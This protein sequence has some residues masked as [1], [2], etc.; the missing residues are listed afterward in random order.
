MVAGEG[1]ILVSPRDDGDMGLYLDSLRRLA[2]LDL[3]VAVPAHGPPTARPRALFERYIEHRL[4]REGRVLDALGRG[5]AATIDALVP[6]VYDD[7]PAAAWPL[8]ALSL[9]AHLD[10]LAREGRVAREGTTWRVCGDG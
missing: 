3:K 5:G 2:A 6:R 1:T 10:K 4:M 9:E 8:A 7:T